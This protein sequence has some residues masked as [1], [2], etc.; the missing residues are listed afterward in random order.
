MTEI[1]NNPG[2]DLQKMYKGLRS[3]RVKIRV[4]E[5]SKACNKEQAEY[6]K[7]QNKYF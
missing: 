6:E 1:Y 2:G 3:E 5:F 7:I 4:E